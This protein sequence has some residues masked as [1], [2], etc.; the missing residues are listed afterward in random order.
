VYWRIEEGATLAGGTY[1]AE[2]FDTPTTFRFGPLV[3]VR[4]PVVAK[5][6]RHRIAIETIT[7]VCIKSHN[8][9]NIVAYRKFPTTDSIRSAIS[10]MFPM[11]VG[12]VSDIRDWDPETVQL[13]VIEHETQVESVDI[14]G[15][16]GRVPGWSGR[17][18]IE[19]NAVARWLIEAASRGPGLGSK[20]AFGLGRVRVTSCPA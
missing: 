1:D 10:N 6:G 13:R 7:P 12:L 3:R 14:G 16:F 20:V 5:R 17:V 8:A 15:K 18:V 4:A 9:G 11:R 2:L 19:C